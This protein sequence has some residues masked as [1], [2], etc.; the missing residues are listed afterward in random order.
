MN[1]QLNW[2]LC[3]AV[4]LTGCAGLGDDY[5]NDRTYVPGQTTPQLM[6]KSQRL[7]IVPVAGRPC[8]P[9]NIYFIDEAKGVR[10][11]VIDWNKLI[12]Y[13][14]PRKGHDD[15]VKRIQKAGQACPMPTL[16]ESHHRESFFRDSNRHFDNYA[17]MRYWLD[18]DLIHLQAR[19]FGF[20]TDP[21]TKQII[22]GNG[23]DSTI[24]PQTGQLRLSPAES[25][26]FDLWGIRIRWHNPSGEYVPYN[27]PLAPPQVVYRIDDHRNFEIV[28]YDQYRCGGRLYYNDTAKGIRTNVMPVN[29]GG[30]TFIIDAANDQYLVA[31]I[32]PSSSG[33]QS[34]G[35]D[36]CADRLYY[37]K[38][39]GRTWQV[40]KP[41]LTNS[42]GDIHLIGDT[43]FYAGQRAKLSALVNGDS[44]WVEFYLV[45]KNAL[46]TI[47]K[48]PIDT[49]FHYCNRTDEK[50]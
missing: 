24:D 39:A 5:V 31:P 46:P 17:F 33:C 22:E 18:G 11:L 30:D 45:G 15:L 1:R 16:V 10:Q 4:L 50:E 29:L 14:M 8:E 2:V 48:A 37:S 34:G 36:K 7:E 25:F 47:R 41:R 32:L 49:E 19:S 3:L 6:G 35:G 43:V 26:S 28:P 23:P 20:E 42:S 13:T 27:G 44:A 40:N 9:A 12:N 21:Q 38:D